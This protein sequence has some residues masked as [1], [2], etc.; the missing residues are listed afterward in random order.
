MAV[1]RG[2]KRRSESR[3][4]E[5]ERPV[6]TQEGTDWRDDAKLSGEKVPSEPRSVLQRGNV[7]SQLGIESQ[8]R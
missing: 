4:R 5:S 3:S 8:C 6:T 2:C 7:D 1:E